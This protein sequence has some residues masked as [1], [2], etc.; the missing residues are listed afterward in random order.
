MPS[1]KVGS[2]TVRVD[3][4]LVHYRGHCVRDGWS[5]KCERWSWKESTEKSHIKENPYVMVPVSNV[6]QY[7]RVCWMLI[8]PAYNPIIE[9]SR[10]FWK[11][12]TSR[13]EDTCFVGIAGRHTSP[14]NLLP[15]CFKVTTPLLTTSSE[16]R[17]LNGWIEIC[18]LMSYNKLHFL[19]SCLYQ[20]SNSENYL[21]LLL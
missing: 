4:D 14:P 11:G 6:L 9:S 21:T 3:A 8:I 15:I 19:L 20:D 5:V 12:N 7:A 17:K 2:V 18:E 10:N 16:T 13:C 1:L